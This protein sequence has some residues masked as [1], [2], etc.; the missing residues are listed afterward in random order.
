MLFLQ[1]L[2]FFQFFQFFH[3]FNFFLNFPHFFLLIS[4]IRLEDLENFFQIL[5]N[6][7]N[8]FDLPIEPYE[9]LAVKGNKLLNIVCEY[10]NRKK[11][12]QLAIKF[13]NVLADYDFHNV[14]FLSKIF[15]SIGNNLDTI[16][17]IAPLLQ[18]NPH[19]FCLI[20]QEAYSLIQLKRYDLAGKL[21][22]SLIQLIPES[23]EAW[24]LLIE[25]YFYSK[26][27]EAALLTL[28]IAPV[29]MK[30]SYFN[31]FS[32]I[33]EEKVAESGI[34]TE[35]KEKGDSD[36]FP[37]NLDVDTPDFR[38]TKLNDEYKYI[39]QDFLEE[40]KKQEEI[41]H[42]LPA[43][44]Y[45]DH[46][47]LLYRVLVKI[48]REISWENLLLLRAKLFLMDEASNSLNFEKNTQKNTRNFANLSS[49]FP[50]NFPSNLANFQ[51]LQKNEKNSTKIED[52][53]I[54]EEKPEESVV[55]AP[56]HAM[57]EQS[58][59]E[60]K[61]A[62][63]S[64][65][66]G[67]QKA[68]EILHRKNQLENHEILHETDEDDSDKEHE[69]PSFLKPEEE[70][71]AKILEIPEKKDQEF[72]GEMSQSQVPANIV[73]FANEGNEERLVIPVRPL[74]IGEISE[75][76]E[77]NHKKSDELEKELNSHELSI[78]NITKKTCIEGVA[79]E[80][81][82]LDSSKKRLCSKLT[83]SL[84]E[85]LYEDLNAL[86]V[87]SQEEYL[88]NSK[89]K[90]MKKIP[91][92]DENEEEFE[93]KE[94]DEED[95]EYIEDLKISG[96]VWV[97][98][99]ILAQRIL[100]N[101]FA[102]TAYRKT[103]ERGFSLYA[104]R[105]LLDIYLEIENFKA[106]LVCIAEILDELENEGV[107]NFVFLPRWIEEAILMIISKAGYKGLTNLLSE[108][109]LDDTSINELIKE[110]AYWKVEGAANV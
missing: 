25:V 37:F 88:K 32:P 34:L 105:Q 106:S 17:L 52:Y 81:P 35:P 104:W 13:F 42:K 40:N 109:N 11:R 66:K 100:R 110:A 36:Y 101:R 72:S 12:Y 79:F 71:K 51:N 1:F 103:V 77:K 90:K 19:V 75:N 39:Q 89:K 108:L 22:R 28:N 58:F 29:N 55:F 56:S 57:N 62:G 95:E 53:E 24:L 73:I 41:L 21:S 33:T 16:K 4:L 8:Q 68:L 93:N 94:E 87:W 98:R 67:H 27:Y 20:Y 84:F 38:Y 50:S 2:Q 23:F 85:A 78:R 54:Y 43:L 14:V 83:D 46:E 7:L 30:K 80:N 99:G 45:R 107:E 61:S 76:P 69:L 96:K 47:L 5:L 44:A 86:Y 92:S 74:K 15:N 102:E 9:L 18:K 63:D 64:L 97:L 91:D 70:K 3:F 10:L 82:L 65:L 26:N 59:N 48:E 31:G 6:S 49:N 60:L